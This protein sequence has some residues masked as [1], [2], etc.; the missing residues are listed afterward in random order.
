MK[1]RG[2]MTMNRFEILEKVEW[3]SE[4]ILCT[5]F[6]R[7]FGMIGMENGISPHWTYPKQ[8]HGTEIICASQ[9]SA[10]TVE[11]D[12]THADG[13]YTMTSG[14]SVGI[15]TADCLPVLFASANIPFVMAVH[16]GWRGLGR[17]IL[18][19]AVTVAQD[20]G[21]LPGSLF[22]V[23][24]PAIGIGAFEVGPEVLEALAHV[25]GLSVSQI[26]GREDRWH[27]DLQ[28]LAVFTL[29]EAGLSPS[30]LSVVRT[31]TYLAQTRWHSFRRQGL[32]M[33]RNWSFVGL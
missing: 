19:R 16:A 25:P 7:S 22:A 15:A 13:I 2:K 3:K 29:A 1:T 17:G 20:H 11:S 5:R 28:Q 8:V 9:V 4:P 26:K 21:V 10:T 33:G 18:S 31:C 24:G 27:I 30:H 23:I 14:A 32:A 6:P 12:R